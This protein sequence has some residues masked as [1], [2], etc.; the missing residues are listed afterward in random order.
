MRRAF[1]SGMVAKK[2]SLP[3]SAMCVSGFELEGRLR[4]HGHGLGG[5]P[6]GVGLDLIARGLQL[7]L[8][9]ER[10]R[11]R[12]RQSGSSGK[13]GCQLAPAEFHACLCSRTSAAALDM[14]AFG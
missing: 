13:S 3:I 7:G 10:P 14:T 2:T 4:V 11:G 1:N 8:G 6:G 9:S 5:Q 12:L